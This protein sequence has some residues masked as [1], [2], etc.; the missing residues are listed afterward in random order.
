MWQADSQWFLVYEGAGMD[1]IWPGDIGLATSSNGYDW[2]KSAQNPVLRHQS[3]GWERNNIG[4]PSLWRENGIWYLFYHGFDGSRVQ[5]GVATGNSLEQMTRVGSE[6][7]LRVGAPGSWDAGTVGW[8]SIRREGGYYY[9]AYEGSTEPPY[10]H[11][12]W[13]TGLARSADLIHWE[14]SPLNP[15]LPQTAPGSGFGYDGPAWVE[16]PD[17]RLQIYY[18]MGGNLTHR[19]TL[20]C[21]G[22]AVVEAL[23]VPGCVAPGEALVFQARL[24]NDGCDPV[25]LESARVEYQGPASGVV[26][27][28]AGAP[29]PVDEGAALET[30]VRIAVPLPA[31]TGVYTL[32]LVAE[33]ADGPRS[34]TFEVRVGTAPTAEIC[35]GLDDD[36]DG[37]FD[38]DFDG[39]GDGY[40]TCGTRTSDGGSV[41]PDCDDSDPNIHP[42]ATELCDGRD[43]NCNQQVDE[44]CDCEWGSLADFLTVDAPVT[45]AVKHMGREFIDGVPGPVST[46]YSQQ[47]YSNST[48]AGK[49]SMV[50]E[51]ISGLPPGGFYQEI[52]MWDEIP[53]REDP[54]VIY[55]AYAS[56]A[57]DIDPTLSDPERCNE[58]SLDGCDYVQIGG[59]EWLLNE[60]E[61]ADSP[62][63]S[64]S[65]PAIQR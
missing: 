24:A 44:T 57:G 26:P 40:T 9:M 3:S 11:A 46:S 18:R 62:N 13:S 51:Q 29:I 30:T 1:G 39:D 48:Y 20:T 33:L 21:S 53:S 17:G 25:A 15:I 27:L 41:P 49:R 4:T 22:D 36:C 52:Y 19:A 16:T 8:R 23:N 42:G 43:Q 54:T 61:A 5:I 14:K 55:L 50:R 63:G 28:Y 10:D 34:D 47:R 64:G 65:S 2:I 60:H 56:L 58:F 6:P 32:T 31:P 59:Q 38:E 37:L 45:Y 35:N 12:Q 7:V